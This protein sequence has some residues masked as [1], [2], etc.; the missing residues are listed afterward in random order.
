[1]QETLCHGRPVYFLGVPTVT[2]DMLR[3][4]L[5]PPMGYRWQPLPENK[6]SSSIYRLKRPSGRERQRRSGELVLPGRE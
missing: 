1:M 3:R 4:K 5:P 6:A 2:E